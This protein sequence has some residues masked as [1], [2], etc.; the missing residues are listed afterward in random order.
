[1]CCDNLYLKPVLSAKHSKGFPD[2]QG[3][4]V[5]PFMHWTLF[6]FKKQCPRKSLSI[7]PLE[8]RTMFSSGYL[9]TQHDSSAIEVSKSNSPAVVADFA[10][11]QK[12]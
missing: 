11:I 10:L 3:L 5:G 7:L 2:R 1:M 6:D 12:P 9:G 4:H 8:A